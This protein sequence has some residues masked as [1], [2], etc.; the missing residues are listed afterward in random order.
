MEVEI[1]ESNYGDYAAKSDLLIL[2]FWATWCGPCRALSPVI[3][4]LAKD[5]EGKAIVGKVNTDE[6]PDLCDKFGIRN[7][8]TVLFLRK[9]ELLD[10]NIGAT[11]KSVLA[12]KIDALLK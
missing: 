9:G 4:E 8:P 2:D 3:A 12:A 7:I 11:T 6:N 1:N 5:Y 10:K